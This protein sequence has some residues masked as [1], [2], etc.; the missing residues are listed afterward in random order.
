MTGLFR[1]RPRQIIG[2][3]LGF[4]GAAILLGGDKFS[5]SITGVGL[6]LLRGL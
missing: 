3:A 4:A 2:L 1:L 5:L 6:V